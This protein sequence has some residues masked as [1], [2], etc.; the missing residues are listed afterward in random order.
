M[1]KANASGLLMGRSDSSDG[2]FTLLELL[3]AFALLAIVLGAVYSTFFL[4][5][6][7]LAGMDDLLIRL[8]ECRAAVDMMSREVDSAFFSGDQNAVFKVEDRDAMG[9][10]A[11]RF[12]FQTFSP[13][14]PGVSVIS[15]YAAKRGGK[16]TLF[17]EMQSSVYQAKTPEQQEQAAVEMVE[18][19]EAFQVEVREKENDQW[20]KTW[21]ASGTKKT[22]FEVRFTIF[23]SAKDR[24]FSISEIAAPKIGRGVLTP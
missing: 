23:F 19:I 4:S 8:Q 14:A 5:H 18:D 13:V 12:T 24:K 11:S 2:G 6:K 16:L 20:L 9:K 17:K 15:Y 21:D 7:A 10:Q 22:P 3:V 1:K